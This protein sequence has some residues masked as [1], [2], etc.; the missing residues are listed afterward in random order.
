M[1]TSPAG[2]IRPVHASRPVD[3][4]APATETRAADS[5]AADTAPADGGAEPDGDDPTDQATGPGRHRRITLLALAVLATASAAALVVGLPDWAS[6]PADA[7]RPLTAAEAER[8][9][10]VRV[11]NYRDVRSGVHVT[12]G[13]GSGRTELV[14][15]VDWSRPLVYLDVGGPGAGTDRGLVQATGAALLARPDPAAA[16]TPAPPPLVPPTDRWRLPAPPAG[17]DLASVVDLL[18]DLGAARTAPDVATLPAAARWTGRDTVAGTPVDVLRAPLPPDTPGSAASGGPEFRL[19]LDP[20]A[21]LHRLAGP[22]PDGTPVTVE[23]ARSDRPTL[24]PIDALGGHPGLPRALAEA[25]TERLARL[26]AR[27]RA[28]GGAT[29]TLTAPLD[30]TRNLR[31]GGWL[32]W[33]GQTAY[34]GVGDVAAPADRTLLRHRAGRVSRVELPAGADTDPAARPP[35]P[36]P[37]GLTWSPARPPGDDLDRL[38]ATAL[39]AGATAVP[40]HSAVRLRDDRVAD[41]TVDVIE[42]RVPR[43][44][45]LRYWIDRTGLLR[46]V[47]LRTGP[48]LWAQLDLSPAAV[49]ALPT[50]GPPVPAPAPRPRRR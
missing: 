45:A 26:P 33:A 16:P 36:P 40:A 38:V 37:S 41:R 20:D 5:G 30:P 22:L 11:T 15:W 6:E 44:P 4:P 18:L 23:L 48:G 35:L 21:R 2:P 31:G 43:S 19:W 14:G 7:A 17:R 28:A 29:L 3:P 9:A 32:N 49:P 10:A 25:E 12:V 50:G 39:R 46:R 47:E 24:R 34:L 1:E 8:L 13:R 42:V 27:L